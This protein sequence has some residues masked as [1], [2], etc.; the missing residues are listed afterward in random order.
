[1]RGIDIII[2]IFIWG[3]LIAILIGIGIEIGR[4]RTNRRKKPFESRGRKKKIAGLILFL[5]GVIAL[6]FGLGLGYDASVTEHYNEAWY[7]IISAT[8]GV[9]LVII[10]IKYFISGNREIDR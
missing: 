8:I 7:A 4:L 9:L 10:G 5:A 2:S 6:F 1:M 3:L